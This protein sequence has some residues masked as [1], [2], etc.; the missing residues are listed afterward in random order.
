M[1]S[2]VISVTLA[3]A[4]FEVRTESSAVISCKTSLLLPEVVLISLSCS[5]SSLYFF[6]LAII[7]ASSSEIS[8]SLSAILF[9]SSSAL[10][11]NCAI[12]FFILSI[13]SLLCRISFSATDT[14]E[15]FS[16]ICD[17]ISVISVLIFSILEEYSPFLM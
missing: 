12:S 6:F 1:L 4:D 3:S 9:I 13:F 2:A 14:R 7:S 10:T 15:R 5:E 11:S 8:F 17:S 16:E